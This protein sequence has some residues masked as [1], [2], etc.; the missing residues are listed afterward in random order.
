MKKIAVLLIVVGLTFSTSSWSQKKL[1]LSGFIGSGVSFFGGPGA[2]SKSTYYRSPVPFPNFTTDVDTMGVP[3]GNKPYTN[4]LAGIN[5]DMKFPSKWILRFSTQYEHTGGRLDADSITTPPVKYK[6]TGTYSRQYDNISFNPQ[7]G[8]VLSQKKLSFILFTGVDYTS[9]LAMGD[10]CE[11]EDQNGQK[12]MI[13][14]S[15][16]EPEV[17]DFRVTLGASVSCK[18]WGVDINY[19]H[20]LTNYNKYGTDKVFSRIFHI[21]LQFA[22]LDKTI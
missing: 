7:I 11:F 14:Y 13:G 10:E 6:T 18:K 3:Y 19:K 15:G 5:A 20:G 1:T 2:V 12:T 17:N 9:K 21:R 8:K 16:G 22:F 4:F